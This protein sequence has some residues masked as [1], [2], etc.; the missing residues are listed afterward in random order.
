MGEWPGIDHRLQFFHEYKNNSG[1]SFRFY[2]DSCATVPEAAAAASQ[3]FGKPVY[4]LT[5]GTDKGLELTPLADTLTGK[6]K[7]ELPVKSLYLL[8]GSATDKLLPALNSAKVK[9]NGPFNS[10]QE[11]L[12]TLKSEIENSTQKEQVVVFSPGATSFGMFA[13]EFDRGNKFMQSVKELFK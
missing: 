1:G 7:N 8:K 10:L 12:N 2:N 5:G 11:M 3:S 9:Y 13:N 6:N 4:L